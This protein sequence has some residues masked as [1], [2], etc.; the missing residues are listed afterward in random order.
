MR[1]AATLTTPT[2]S[3]IAINAAAFI[4]FAA[5]ALAANLLI[6]RA[7]GPNVT[8]VFNQ[9]LAL[10]VV[11]SQLAVLGTHIAALREASLVD[12]HPEDAQ[13]VSALVS[14]ALIAVAIPSATVATLGY[15]ASF[16]LPYLFEA[17]GLAEAWRLALPG[18]FFFALNKVL[19]N[20]A[21]GFSLFRVYAVAQ[22]GRSV[23]FLG[24]C[25][26][27]V[28]AGWPGGTLPLALTI[29]EVTLGASLL[30]ALFAYA[31]PRLPEDLLARI[32]RFYRFG[33]KAAPSVGFAELN[34]R[35]DIIVLGLF[36]PVETVGVYTVAAW[37][38]EGAIQLPAAMRPLFS[39]GLARDVVANHAHLRK[40]MRR[41]GSGMA[42]VMAGLLATIC[43][44]Y[45]IAAKVLLV[46]P[47][48]QAAH[49]PLVI[50]SVGVAVAS[51]ALPFDLLL[52]QAGRPWAHS[53]FKGM[54]TLTNLALALSLVPILGTTG[55]ALA[56]G[57][58]LVVYTILLQIVARG[59]LISHTRSVSQKQ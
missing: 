44:V 5:G 13:E 38:I 59:M 17:R 6:A 4:I 25:G 42:L 51:Y 16:A 39:P 36:V 28:A 37:L 27:W 49:L 21:T 20:L 22:G 10:Y 11:A 2:R 45:P 47:R 18:L 19:I 30:I 15:I 57:S 35:V 58:S 9:V 26:L 29:T 24:A 56:Y 34:S 52:A 40:V 14:S 43:V 7:Y 54:V 3:D 31:S 41:V 1:K 33:I 8:G 32:G 46:D 23:L 48:Y 50:L 53:A 55:A 12:D